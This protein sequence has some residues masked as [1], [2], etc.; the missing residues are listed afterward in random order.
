[1]NSAK[2]SLGDETFN[3]FW[4]EYQNVMSEYSTLKIIDKQ[5]MCR[6]KNT[7]GRNY[8]VPDFNKSFVEYTCSHSMSKAA[9][10]PSILHTF[11]TNSLVLGCMLLSFSF[12]WQMRHACLRRLQTQN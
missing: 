12:F 9:T 10:A 4:R 6:A 5:R 1:L 7:A 2:E 8:M 11:S 3:S